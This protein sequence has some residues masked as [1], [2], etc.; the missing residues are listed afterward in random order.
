MKEKSEVLTDL[1]TV[2]HQISELIHSLEMIRDRIGQSDDPRISHVQDDLAELINSLPRLRRES[3]WLDEHNNKLQSLAGINQILN[4]TLDPNDILQIVM[5]TLVRLIGAE[6]GFLML[7]DDK[8]DLVVKIARNWDQST[9]E[10]SEAVFSRTVVNQVI[11][12]SKPVLTTNALQDPRFDNQQSV[13]AHQ[14]RSILCVPL[15]VKGKIIGVIYADNRIKTGLFTGSD[16]DLLAVFA[17]QAAVALENARLFDSLLQSFA[18]VS[19]LKNLLQDVFASITSGVITIDLDHVINFANRAALKILDSKNFIGSQINDLACFNQTDLIP[20]I[21]KVYAKNKSLNN[22]RLSLDIPTRGRIVLNCSISLL[23]NEQGES[24]GTVLVFEDLTERLHLEAR[25]RLFERMVSPAIISELNPDELSLGGKHG[26]ITTLFADLHGFTGWSEQTDPEELITSLNRF[27][28]EAATAILIEGGTID[29]FVGD[30]IMA[31]FNAPV[32]QDNH[33]LRALKAAWRMREA[34]L[35]RT[36]Q[37]THETIP[38][39]GIGI[40]TGEAILGLIGS[41]E[42][43]DY[44]AIGDSVNTAKRVQELASAG[45]ILIT[46][47]VYELVKSNL[48]ARSL[49]TLNLRGKQESIQVYEVLGFSE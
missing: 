30:A 11:A 34:F 4:S 23:Q 22:L 5:D 14:L 46:A 37:H 47:P 44:T 19:D 3:L 24:Q 33:A 48:S 26:E 38:T 1:T 43:M 6:R 15:M 25:N 18:E 12:T 20:L 36:H 49:P 32:P 21:H 9:I 10:E 17:N 28:G 39:F 16:R 41:P 13:I 40:H 31:F 27:L 45:Q 8:Q 35:L 29:K 2:S 42:R 7:M